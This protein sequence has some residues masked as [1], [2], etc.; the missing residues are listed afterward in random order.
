M[1]SP[2]ELA[3]GIDVQDD[4]F[5]TT[6]SSLRVNSLPASSDLLYYYCSHAEAH[7]I[8]QKGGIH[9]N[10]NGSIVMT[11]KGPHECKIGDPDLESM[12]PSAATR[13][14]VSVPPQI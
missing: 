8:I 2:L 5:R 1:Q 14:T 13:Q 10:G 12:G 11:L 7:L 6:F 9:C 3:D 4:K